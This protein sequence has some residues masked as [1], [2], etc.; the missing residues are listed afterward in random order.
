MDP[1][2]KE[3]FTEFAEAISKKVLEYRNDDEF[4]GF[5]EELIRNICA[6]CELFLTIFLSNFHAVLYNCIFFSAFNKY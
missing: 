1:K 4:S 2:T 3:E 5:A 6:S